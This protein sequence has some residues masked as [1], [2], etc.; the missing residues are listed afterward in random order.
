MSHDLQIYPHQESTSSVVCELNFLQYETNIHNYV[1]D[2][3][4][5]EHVHKSETELINS[6]P[7]C[8]LVIEKKSNSTD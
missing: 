6:W 8:L 5:L 1:I 7:G 4:S 3:L 2:L